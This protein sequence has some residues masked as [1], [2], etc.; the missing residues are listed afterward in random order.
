MALPTDDVV[1]DVA[2]DSIRRV[3]FDVPGDNFFDPNAELAAVQ[4]TRQSIRR[5]AGDSL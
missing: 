1:T 3:A 2:D 4:L 5:S